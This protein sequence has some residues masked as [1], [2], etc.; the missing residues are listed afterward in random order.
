M[1]LGVGQLLGHVGGNIFSVILKGNVINLRRDQVSLWL[2]IQAK[3]EDRARE[4]F[5]KC[6]CEGDGHNHDNTHNTEND[7]IGVVSEL[8]QLGLLKDT[9][10]KKDIMSLMELRPIRQ[11]NGKGYLGDSMLIQTVYGELELHDEECPVWLLADGSR[12]IEEISKLIESEIVIPDIT[13]NQAKEHR[14]LKTIEIIEGMA[15]VSAMF[16]I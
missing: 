16:I 12:T 13:S 8:M 7:W 6:K 1:L 3:G 2:D 4:E 9:N 11:G 10:N 14:R 5:L 15:K